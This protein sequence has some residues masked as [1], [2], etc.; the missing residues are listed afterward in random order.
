MPALVEALSAAAF[1][2]QRL[3]YRN[4]HLCGV[5]EIEALAIA[6]VTCRAIGRAAATIAKPLLAADSQ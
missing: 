5:R 2:A 3:L 4:G 1:S 6:G